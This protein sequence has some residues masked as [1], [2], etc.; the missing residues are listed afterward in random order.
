MIIVLPATV[1]DAALAFANVPE[2]EYPLYSAT[3][4][5]GLGDTVLVLGTNIHYVYQSTVAGNLNNNPLSFAVTDLTKW[6]RVG[7]DNRWKMFDGSITSQT[8]NAD[9]IAVT[10][11]NLGVVTAVNVLNINAAS[12]TVTLTDNADG[13]VYN[14]TVSL[15]ATSNT[16][17]EYSWCFAPVVR[18]QDYALTDLPPYANATIGVTLNDLGGTVTCGALVAGQGEDFGAINYGAQ[19][20]IQDY[21]IKQKDVFG[22]YTILPRAFNKYANE[23]F[24]VQNSLVD[25]LQSRLS[26][27][28][29]TPI[30]YVGNTA[31]GA[32]IIYGFYKDFNIAIAY[33][34]QSLCT[35]N[36]EGL[37]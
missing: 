17:D 16:A 10:L 32:T 6:Q 2:N 4:T 11:T 34:T 12:L 37:T 5:Y 35:M 27:Y 33:P 7:N 21:S 31:F 20:G 36:L 9:S 3:V 13:L 30:V 15:V 24:Y 22:N 29:A 28:R 25:Y 18:A 23:S 26:K 19:V 1:N 8:S 14:N